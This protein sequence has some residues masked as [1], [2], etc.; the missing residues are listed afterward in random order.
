MEGEK[1]VGLEEDYDD[2]WP[3]LIKGKARDWPISDWTKDQWRIS[4][5]NELVTVKK[6]R[7]GHTF[8]EIWHHSQADTQL[9]GFSVI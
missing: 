6:S 5:G 4:Y 9:V 1:F 3:L 7:D 8:G 2:H